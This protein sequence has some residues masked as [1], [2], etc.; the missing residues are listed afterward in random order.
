M[1]LSQ[2]SKFHKRLADI[3]NLFDNKIHH[4]VQLN[5]PGKLLT[6]KLKIS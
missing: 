1:I 4:H 5:T 2:L 6:F 3:S